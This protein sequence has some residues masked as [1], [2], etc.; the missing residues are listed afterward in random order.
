M[1]SGGRI[2]DRVGIASRV[3]G[4]SGLADSMDMYE[5]VNKCYL[6]RQEFRGLFVY[7]LYCF[8]H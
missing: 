4:V 7:C 8:V 2:T 6:F 3:Y 5:I 1:L